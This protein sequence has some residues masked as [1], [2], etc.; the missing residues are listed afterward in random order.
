MAPVARR[1]VFGNAVRPR[2]LASPRCALSRSLRKRGV[3]SKRHLPALGPCSRSRRG[4]I[5]R[6]RMFDA[7]RSET[8]NAEHLPR[9]LPDASH[10]VA[11]RSCAC[12]PTRKGEDLTSDRCL[13][14]PD[15]WDSSPPQLGASPDRGVMPH[16]SPSIAPSTRNSPTRSGRTLVECTPVRLV[17]YRT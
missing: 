1:C 7:Q 4:F 14:L 17:E 13:A 8:S 2:N 5:T 16:L 9:V 6:R 3:R 11:G 12:V 10:A 15:L